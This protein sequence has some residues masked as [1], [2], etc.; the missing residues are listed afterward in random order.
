MKTKLLLPLLICLV[1]LL[2]AQTVTEVNFTTAE[3]FSSGALYTNVN[4]DATFSDKTWEVDA[5]T[6][7]TS[8]A[9]E[10]K[11]AVWGMPFDLSSEGDQLTFRVD[12][13]FQG[14][15]DVDA[16]GSKSIC[17]FGFNTSALVG[18]VEQNVVYLG[19][20]AWNKSLSLKGNSNVSVLSPNAVLTM[21][22]VQGKSLAIE[23]TFVLGSSA[24][25]SM[26]YAKIVNVT[27]GL[28]SALGSYTG[29]NEAIYTAATTTGLY[30]VFHSQNFTLGH[31]ITGIDVSMVTMTE[32]GDVLSI[33]TLETKKIIVS[34]NPSNGIVK[35]QGVKANSIVAVY[36][37]SGAKVL[38]K[39]YNGSSFD[40]SNLSKGVYIIRVGALTQRI[41]L[42]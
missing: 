5:N 30:G 13:D 38:E 23:V 25:T 35:L 7:D 31:P 15:L 41:I 37:V 6:G 40:L 4:W 16:A 19:S 14:S 21:E 28:E 9:Y 29:V 3:G 22:S 33:P 32:E 20:T 26:V 12:F 11:R 36:A 2:N 27:D 39:N 1:S 8:T 17:L 34:P 18:T 24:A 42:I 10:W